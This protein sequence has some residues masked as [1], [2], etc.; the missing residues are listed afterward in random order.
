MPKC[1]SR[2]ET[3]FSALGDPTRM[4]VIKALCQ[5]PQSVSALAKGHSMSLPS[6]MQHLGLLERSGWIA[7][8][9][10][11]RVRNCRVNPEALQAAGHWLLRQK[12]VWEGRLN[13]LDA[14]ANQLRKETEKH[15]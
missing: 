3:L 12:A 6:F 4:T 1:V 2:P 14:L 11:G 13:R 9:K 7:T 8:Q 10:E 5:G 15:V